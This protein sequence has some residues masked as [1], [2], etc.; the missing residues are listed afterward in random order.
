MTTERRALV[1]G[2]FRPALVLGESKLQ[3]ETTYTVIFVLAG[4]LAIL[5]IWRFIRA[6]GTTIGQIKFESERDRYQHQRIEWQRE[7][8]YQ[9]F[10]KASRKINGKANNI[11]W[12]D[13]DRRAH[14]QL[15]V[16]DAAD[17]VFDLTTEPR[18]MDVSTPWGWPSSSAKK[19]N[20]AGYRV[21]ATS[22]KRKGNAFVN[23]FKSKQV[24]DEEYKARRARSIRHL[25]EDRYGRVSD[26]P[27]MQEVE[28]A[29]P[30]LPAALLKERASDQ[31]LGRDNKKH[32][33]DDMKEI[34]ALRLVS[35][36][37]GTVKA[38]QRALGE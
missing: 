8:E 3:A 25:V 19:V 17:E 34:R 4:F 20:R 10:R 24:I 22:R 13:S 11:H 21:R 36:V 7:R 38:Q 18:A 14:R 26:T 6:A 27:Q 9:Q 32:S 12:D 37:P 2:K 28:W 33:I 1:S 30:E 23:F 31:V 5:T 15:H 16:D 35:D 29:S